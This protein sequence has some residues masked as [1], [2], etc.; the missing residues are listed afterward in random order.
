L[1]SLAKNGISLFIWNLPP[2]MEIPSNVRYL[3]AME[4]EVIS[5]TGKPLMTSNSIEISAT[6]LM[7]DK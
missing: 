5:E 3:M 6:A 4:L 1:K 2:R 7:R